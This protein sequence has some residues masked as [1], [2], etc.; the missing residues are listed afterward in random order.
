MSVD[1]ASAVNSLATRPPIPANMVLPLESAP[2]EEIRTDDDI[3]PHCRR[4]LSWNELKAAEALASDGDDVAICEL[5]SLFSVGTFGGFLIS[6]STSKAM[7]AS[8]R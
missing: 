6:V 3:A 7:S 8:F 2:L 1:G 4:K 5:V